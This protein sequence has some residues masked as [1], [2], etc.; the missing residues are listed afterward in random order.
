MSKNPPA[1]KLGVHNIYLTTSSNRLHVN[2]EQNTR[3]KSFL[4]LK[5]NRARYC[6]YLAIMIYSEDGPQ[7]SRK[8]HATLETLLQI[9]VII[10]SLL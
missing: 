1:V 6:V 8:V 2:T 10:L 3:L 4:T 5:F 9:T 7:P